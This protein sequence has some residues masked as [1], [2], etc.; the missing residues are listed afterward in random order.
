VASELLSEPEQLRDYLVELLEGKSDLDGARKLSRKVADL[1]NEI[2]R[3]LDKES[4]S[5]IVLIPSL[6]PKPHQS[7]TLFCDP[8][9]IT[10]RVIENVLLN[11]NKSGKSALYAATR[12][13]AA[14]QL[15]KPPFA[16]CG[17]ITVT[18]LR[19]LNIIPANPDQDDEDDYS[20]WDVLATTK[21][22]ITPRSTTN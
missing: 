6:K 5:I 12:V 4:L 22:T 2:L 3:S 9:N 21:L 13:G 8:A 16:W 20:A 10:V 1:Q 7:G 14:L 17:E 15:H 19:E 18:D 11:K